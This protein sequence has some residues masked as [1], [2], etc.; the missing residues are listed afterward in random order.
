MMTAELATDPKKL[1]RRA[2][3]LYVADGDPGY[4]RQRNG[5]GLIYLNCRGGRL[6]DERMIQR[7]EKLAI[8]PA[9]RE[10]WICVSPKGHLQ[11]TGRDD[12]NRKQYLYHE[13]WHEAAN[14]DKFRR[15]VRFGRVLPRLRRAV[16]HDMR[17]KLLTR[18]R[19]LS[20]IVALLD[21]TSIR[22][23]NEEYV[24][25]NN[26]YGLTTLRSRHV[27]IDR[28]R[29]V[30]RFRGKSGIRREV[31]VE[32]KRLVRL[33]KQC[34]RLKGAHLFQY[35]DEDGKFHV[36]TSGDVN[37]Y[38]QEQLKHPFTAKTFRI[39]KA[40]ALVAGILYDR[41][42]VDSARQRATIARKAIAAA[43]ELLANTATICRKYYVHPEL[44]ESYQSGTFGNV[45]S[46]FVPRRQNGH[47]RDEQI[48]ARFL[49]NSK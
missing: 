19:V 38:L 12:R 24:R 6:R 30:L 17:G 10:V 27:A 11:A 48:L 34:R 13:L 32:E 9:W 44:I 33:L 47:T 23:G 7:I 28:G 26:S 14:K 20:G 29:A 46:R 22:V 15:F 36:A 18:R 37:T 45:F 16:S 25:N 49:Q 21:A 31:V 42:D 4:S 2:G 39:W 43:A 1:A 41:R 8:P 35:A 40:S 3:L 5:H